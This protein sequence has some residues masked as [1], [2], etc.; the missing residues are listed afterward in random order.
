MTRNAAFTAP[1]AEDTRLR[2]RTY[3][4]PFQDVWQAALGLVNGGL[5]RWEVT[6]QDD[7]EGIIRGR[8][9]SR[10]P[11]LDGTIT[12]RITLDPDAQTRVDAMSAAHTARRDLGTSARRIARFF[13]ELDRALAQAGV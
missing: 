5:A 7:H 8:I 10:L 9:R 3:A 6:E 4:I 11:K 2:G 13:R 1:E 12:V